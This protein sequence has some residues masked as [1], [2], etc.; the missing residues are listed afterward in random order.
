MATEF[1]VVLRTGRMF[2]YPLGIRMRS[3]GHPSHHPAE[4]RDESVIGLKFQ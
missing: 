3:N 2:C 1:S 4:I